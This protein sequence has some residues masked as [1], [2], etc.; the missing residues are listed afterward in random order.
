M[1]FPL[2][3]FE[4]LGLSNGQSKSLYISNRNNLN[5]EILSELDDELSEDAKEEG[6]NAGKGKGT[7]EGLD[8]EKW[9]ELLNRLEENTGFSN[10]FMQTFEDIAPNSQVSDRYIHRERHHED[11]VVK[12]VFPTIHS[13][14]KP[15]E[16][17]L[18][19]APENLND[20]VERNEII[21]RY[22][23]QEPSEASQLTVTLENKKTQSNF[24]P[25]HFPPEERQR[26]FDSSLPDD[27][28]QQLT[29]FIQKYFNYDPNEGD[30]PI[31]TRELYFQNLERLLYT[32]SSDS[33][34]FFLDF[35]LENL[36][37]E[38]F[39]NNAL[40]QAGRL[41]G[42]KTSTELLFALERI[43]EI[44]QR[45]WGAYFD[46]ENVYKKLPEEKKNRLRVETLRRVDERYKSVL[47]KKGIE[48]FES[49]EEKYLQR[50]YEIM[51]H[52][53]NNTPDGYRKQDALFEQAV[54]LWQMGLQKEDEVKKQQAI[55]Q[56]QALISQAR[57]QK[58]SVSSQPD[59]QNLPHLPLLEALI[60]NYQRDEGLAKTQRERQISSMLMQRQSKRLEEKRKREAELLWPKD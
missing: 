27:K 36:N 56:W 12:E 5:V 24:G 32:F 9:G 22:R 38:D 3:W 45:A 15:F 60:V 13:I 21:K 43:Y 23:S 55:S 6:K 25:L 11:I 41:D 49:I 18:Q 4:R 51:E 59:F 37:K 20:F 39:L 28:S 46:F 44:Q 58:Y 26:F 35:Y 8:Q 1:Y 7:G 53:I 33:T 14:D 48:N 30:L 54:I 31:A 34:Y 47:E 10:D 40:Y 42:S 17:I 52:I 29:E 2:E 50:R 57:Q 16:E 19:Q